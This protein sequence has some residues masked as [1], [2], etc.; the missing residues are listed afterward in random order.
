M[1]L[2]R[3]MLPRSSPYGRCPPVVA[4]SPIH[5]TVAVFSYFPSSSSSSDA[6]N[7]SDN[8][9]NR[10]SSWGCTCLVPLF[11]LSRIGGGRI[12]PL[13]ASVEREKEE[14]KE[15]EE[16][17]QETEF[18]IDRRKA[19]EALRKLDRQLQS[20]SQPESLPKKRPPPA[21]P[22]TTLFLLPR[23]TR[24]LCSFSESIVMAYM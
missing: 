1:L 22:G 8:N 6:T 12:S 4:S 13:N 16:E 24:S 3:T 19:R 15:E 20:L 23:N 9:N 5:P 21:L 11:R 2:L 7:N 17:E 18:E 10:S 14:E